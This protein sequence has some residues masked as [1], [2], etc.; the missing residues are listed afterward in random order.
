M[1]VLN[2]FIFLY[3]H[4]TLSLSPPLSPLFFTHQAPSVAAP[5]YTSPPGRARWAGAS[6]GC[7]GYSLVLPGTWVTPPPC[8][9][10]RCYHNLY[11][12]V[13]NHAPIAGSIAQ[14]VDQQS[15]ALQLYHGR[16]RRLGRNLVSTLNLIF[17]AW[18]ASIRTHCNKGNMCT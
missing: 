4:S 3:P 17:L 15:S 11:K 18:L 10:A 2:I 14:T 9:Y 8:L 1:C 13:M 6:P 5:L 12:N 7:S 16:P